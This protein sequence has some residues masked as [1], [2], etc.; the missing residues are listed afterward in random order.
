MVPP[1]CT[2]TEK[3]CEENK[4]YVCAD[5]S[6]G[7]GTDC[8]TLGCNDA[9]KECNSAVTPECEG[10]EKKCE[11]N[12]AYVC[13]DGS[14]G[15]GT[16][17][18]TL[19]CNTETKECNTDAP[20]CTGTEKK[21]EENKAYVC[22]DGS[23]GTGTDCGTLGC[24]DAT[25]ECNTEVPPK[26]TGTE[27]KCESN[28]AYVC[29]DGSWG[30][31]TDCGTLGCN[32]ATKECN[33]EVPPECTGT[34]KKCESNKA[35]VCADGSWG[36]GTDCG[37]LGCNDATKECNT[38]VPPVPDGDI[39]VFG[40][41]YNYS[42]TEHRYDAGTECPNG[43]DSRG[44]S[45]RIVAHSDGDKMCIG[46]RAYTYAGGSWGSGTSCAN[47]CD[48]D[49][50]RANMSC[51]D[52]SD[53][54][55]EDGY[56][57]TCSGGSLTK[58]ACSGY[59]YCVDDASCDHNLEYEA[60]LTEWLDLLAD[61]SEC[62]TF[63]ETQGRCFNR[64]YLDDS[65][66]AMAEWYVTETC[67]PPF[68]SQP[69]TFQSDKLY[70]QVTAAH[71]CESG[72]CSIGCAE[73][74]LENIDDCTCIPENV[75]LLKAYCE[76]YKVSVWVDDDAPGSGHE[77][78]YDR[79][80]VFSRRCICKD[81]DCRWFAESTTWEEDKCPAEYV[82]GFNCSSKNTP[83][84]T[85][86]CSNIIIDDEGLFEDKEY[87][88]SKTRSYCYEFADGGESYAI[89]M[90][91]RCD[92]VDDDSYTGFSCTPQYVDSTTVSGSCD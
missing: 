64:D 37:T 82:D 58:S 47:G 9:T 83:S 27:K 40:K 14:W 2:G 4:A 54:Y 78:E 51:T 63:G 90:N 61:D 34:E 86:W 68:A 55:C 3:K 5:G 87:Y 45:C 48:G 80:N 28:K 18:G 32:D 52:A 79:H 89:R 42:E 25:K 20:E 23:W 65:R 84:D 59:K 19:G 7:T 70:W 41:V 15:T 17:C 81:S 53:N 1:E 6:W 11:S 33:T 69:S 39:C 73:W 49:E 13:S 46:E 66:G 75:G 21:C 8:G 30:T 24:N 12:K 62:T 22:S 91:Y 35:Y 60:D 57:Y 50:C 16:D 67:L 92:C 26:C 10:T 31:G 36:T 85:A 43:C 76:N 38:E 56:S 29:A 71:E 77:V 88:S 44:K 72:Q 74:D